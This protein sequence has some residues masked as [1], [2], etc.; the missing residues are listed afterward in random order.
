M[1]QRVSAGSD[2]P[3]GLL[4]MAFGLVGAWMAW[5]LRMGTAVSMGPGYYPLLIFSAIA[6]LGL[7]VAVRGLRG[8]GLQAAAPLWRPLVFVTASLLAFALL[9]D[10]A[11]FVVAGMASMLLSIKAQSHLDWRRAILLSSLTVLATSLIFVV[12][13]KLPFPLWPTFF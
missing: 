7:V 8:S 4:L 1:T 12:G 9:V 2:L 13:L 11:G 5:D 10:K 3:A 6:L